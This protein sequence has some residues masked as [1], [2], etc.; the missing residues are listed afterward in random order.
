MNA[1]IITDGEY[2]TRVYDMLSKLAMQLLAEKGFELQVRELDRSLH[3]C[4]GCFGCWI[5]KPGECM[6]SDEMAELNR[7]YMDSDAVIFLSP[8]VFGQFSANI[9]NAIDRALPNMLPFFYRRPDGSTMHPP[10]YEKSPALLIIGYGEGLDSEEVQLFRDV[11]EKHR[12][13]VGVEVYQGE[14]DTEKVRSLFGALDLS[15]VRKRKE[16]QAL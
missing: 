7:C 1:L 2:K 15:G 6:I 11:T 8:V 10:R 14:S 13:D 5:K 16:A 9:K 4:M 12:Y 3:S